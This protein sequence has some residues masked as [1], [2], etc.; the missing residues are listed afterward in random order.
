MSN[1]PPYIFI[2]YSHDD[3]GY[4]HRLAEALEQEG[5]S[6]W[7]DDRIDYGTQWPDIIE[8]H[9]DSSSAFVVIMTPR[10]HQSNWVK[11][12]LSRAQRK[13]KPIYPLLLEGD[14]PWLSVEATQY[15]DVR[16]GAMPP[17][18]FYENLAQFIPRRKPEGPTAAIKDPE[19]AQVVARVAYTAPD[20]APSPSPSI[21][22]RAKSRLLKFERERPEMSLWLAWVL[23]STAGGAVVGT[24]GVVVASTVVGVVVGVLQWLVLRRRIA[25][26]GW[27]VLAT[28]VGVAVGGAVGVAL[29][30]RPVGGIVT[31]AITGGALV[32]LL[33]RT[34]AEV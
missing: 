15:V 3:K 21:V 7:I 4:A 8:E 17:Q 33:R 9:L 5:L 31:P 19:D 32:W 24:V 1:R 30:A 14:E 12:E 34:D 10:S 11:N 6:A 18:D 25:S 20:K 26:A 28:T 13:G 27:W 29:D 23:F 2:S 16:S 22:Q